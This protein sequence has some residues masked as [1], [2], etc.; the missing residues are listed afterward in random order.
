MVRDAVG[1][2]FNLHLVR[3][4]VATLLYDADPDN[5]PVAQRVLGHAQLKTTERIYGTLRTRGAQRNW[6]DLLDRR[7]DALRRS[8]PPGRSRKNKP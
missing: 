8:R 1:A 6:A 2:E 7:R 5:G 3:H 4:L